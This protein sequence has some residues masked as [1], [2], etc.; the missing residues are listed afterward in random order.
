VEKGWMDGEW[1]RYFEFVLQVRPGSNQRKQGAPVLWS[2][3]A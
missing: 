3:C 1:G 2:V